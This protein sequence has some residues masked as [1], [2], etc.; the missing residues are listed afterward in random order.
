L[1]KRVLIVD[2]ES[3]IRRALSLLLEERGFET[4]VASGGAEALARL[5]AQS[6]ALMLCDVAMPGMSGIEL[7]EEAR[8]AWPDLPVI[9]ISA[10][11]ELEMAVPAVRAGAYDYLL[12]PID[13]ERLFHTIDQALELHRLAHENRTLRQET[14]AEGELLGQSPCMMRL[15][16]EIA[17]A[18]PSE[19]RILILGENGV[20]KEV[21]ARLIHDHSLRRDRPFVKVNS[22][23]IPRDLIESELF[24]HEAGAFT[25]ATR[26]RKGKLESAD[27]GTLFLDE[28]GDMS[29]EVQARLLRVLA[30]GE[31]ERVGGSRP[32]SFDVRLITATN[33]DLAREIR[34]GR[35]REDLYHRVAVIPIRVPP[36]RERGEDILLLARHFLGSFTAGYRRQPPEFAADAEEVLQRYPWP[37]NVRELRNLM[38]RIA[39]MH[40]RPTVTG[41]DLGNLLGATSPFYGG[42][43]APAEDA[44]PAVDRRALL[45]EEERW[46]L[47]KTLEEC[48][49]RVSLAAARLKI[50]RTTFH[51]RMRRLGIERPKG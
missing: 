12:K 31:L 26:P 33:Q 34:E 16:E 27:G 49:W 23:A 21:V 35:F 48:G 7:L 6:F 51:R 43:P 25:G 47:L 29:P 50:D 14:A 41:A 8:R 37:G 2:D 42:S 45:E 1:K 28:I 30:T 20:G 24:G 17:R 11:G 36:L 40:P 18:A 10:H 13:E 32:I 3:R 15:R 19:G 5:E 4:V 9:M 44:P 39:I 46:L 22:A 38:E